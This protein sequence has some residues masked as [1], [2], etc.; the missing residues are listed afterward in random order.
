MEP[1]G[2]HTRPPLEGV[3][4]FGANE[5]LN[6][7]GRSSIGRALVSKTRGWGFD[8]LRPCQARGLRDRRL[9][10]TAARKDTQKVPSGFAAERWLRFELRCCCEMK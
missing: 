9:A 3:A 8:A 4:G 5:F 10:N 7:E 2:V 1:P 6:Q